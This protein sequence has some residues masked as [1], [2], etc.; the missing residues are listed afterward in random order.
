[1]KKDVWRR[2][3]KVTRMK[4]ENCSK[5]IETIRK[6]F[7]NGFNT[8]LKENSNVQWQIAKHCYLKV[9][10][11][12]FCMCPEVLLPNYLHCISHSVRREKKKNIKLSWWRMRDENESQTICKSYLS[13]LEPICLI[14]TSLL[15]ICG[16]RRNDVLQLTR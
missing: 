11:F 15:T 2:I 1:M 12:K 13:H 5:K 6:V 10:R 14:Y 9:Y 16:V 8:I 7:Q 4:F 3:L